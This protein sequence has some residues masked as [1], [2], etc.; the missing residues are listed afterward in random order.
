MD[1]NKRIVE[2]NVDN[3]R[4]FHFLRKFKV[5]C[6]SLIALSAERSKEWKQ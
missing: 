5:F 2:V 1:E 4:L 3:L 6:K